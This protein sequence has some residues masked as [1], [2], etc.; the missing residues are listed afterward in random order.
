MAE[1]E[2]VVYGTKLESHLET[3]KDRILQKLLRPDESQKAANRLREQ[4]LLATSIAQT[5]LDFINV[6][7]SEF[8]L[9]LIN[10]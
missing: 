3:W 8:L 7:A 6:I 1:D 9:N 2:S 5:H 10:K 4:L